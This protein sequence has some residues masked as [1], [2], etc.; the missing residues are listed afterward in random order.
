VHEADGNNPIHPPAGHRPGTWN[1]YG[2]RLL[3]GSHLRLGGR[4][5]RSPFRHAGSEDRPV[6]F[7]AYGVL[8]PRCGKEESDRDAVDR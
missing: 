5:R 7:H 6:L 4:F 2:G 3:A 1:A 8:E